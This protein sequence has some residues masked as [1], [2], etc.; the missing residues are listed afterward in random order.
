MS[1]FFSQRANELNRNGYYFNTTYYIT[2]AWRAISSNWTLFSLFTIL[3]LGTFVLFFVTSPRIAQIIQ[4]IIAGPISAGYYLT[5]QKILNNTPIRFDNFF[6]GFK[7][8]IPTMMINLL[9][10]IIVS[11]GIYF[12]IIPGIFALL[13]YIFAMPLVVF[14]KL[15]YIKALESSR[16]I[17][18][19]RFFET[20]IFGLLIL[21]INF[22]G[23]LA[24]GIG[25]IITIPL[26]YAMILVAYKDIYGFEENETI[27]NKFDYF[28]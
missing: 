2:T 13:I 9:V 15:N 20:A 8:F 5:I 1:Q 4:M 24:F 16:I 26:S 25:V 21:L 18:F 14:G 12:Y 3:Y 28:R 23:L 7:I 6:D 10:N 19:K 17:V 11:V 27:E 22:V